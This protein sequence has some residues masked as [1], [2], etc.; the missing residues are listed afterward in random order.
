M[1]EKQ[2]PTS[3]HLQIYRWNI[4]SLTSIMHRFTGVVLYTSVV[5]ICWY[6]VYY[7]YQI[8]IAQS[9]EEICDCPMQTIL[10][11]VLLAAIVGITF[12]LYYHLCNGVRHLFWDIGKGFEKETARTNG[13]LVIV[14]SLILT[15][16]TV[17]TAI[18][19]K[20]F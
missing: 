16:I 15:I 11:Y 4:S 5:A 8:N 1:T 20:L 6:I 9:G 18:Y 17:G 7:T 13:F 19:L 10:K 12:S 2:R 14:S 3:P